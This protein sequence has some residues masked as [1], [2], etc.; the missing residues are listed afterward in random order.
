MANSPLSGKTICT[1]LL[2]LVDELRL[3]ADN[4]DMIKNLDLALCTILKL[5][6]VLKEVEQGT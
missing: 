6:A 3:L 4:V 5:K 1:L 2:V